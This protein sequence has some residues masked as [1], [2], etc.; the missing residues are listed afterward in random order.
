MIVERYLEYEGNKL[1]LYDTLFP[2][3]EGVHGNNLVS[4]D[5]WNKAAIVI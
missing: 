3:P 5:V 4:S 1:T 2:T